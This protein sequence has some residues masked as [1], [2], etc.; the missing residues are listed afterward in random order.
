[1]M[2]IWQ[3]LFPGIVSFAAQDITIGIAR[4]FLIFFG[5][6]LAY[7][8][9]NRT[10]EP[11]IMVPMGIGMSAVNAGSLFLKDG[12]IGNLFLDPLVAQP[13]ALVNIMQINFLR[14]T[15]FV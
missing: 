7:L 5:M 6:G 10:L 15:I 8:G 4:L 3:N 9:F 2:E 1:M 11:L 13:D 12:R 14:Y